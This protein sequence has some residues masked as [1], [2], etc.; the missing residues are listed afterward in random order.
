MLR[1]TALPRPFALRRRSAGRLSLSLMAAVAGLHGLVPGALAQTAAG[2]AEAVSRQSTAAMAEQSARQ[3]ADRILTAVR[4]RDANAYF[5]QLA[6][7]PQR[8]SSP[9]MAAQALQRLPKLESW[10]ISDVV[11]GLDSSSVTAQ[12]KTSAGPREV[13]L[14]IDGKGRLEGYHVNVTDAKAEDVVR[15]FIQA[16][17][18]GYFVT[19]SSY[20]SERMREEIPQPVLQRKWLNLQSITGQFQSVKKIT[21]AE[22]NEQM[23]L[24]I[25]ST[26]FNRLTDNLY[27]I[28]DSSNQIIGVDFPDSPNPS[29]V[30]T[31]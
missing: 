25:V 20:L 2:A 17:S 13:L 1:P 4:N 15:A 28:L 27:V 8:V 21:R 12:L 29:P 23:K 16:L 18:R 6:P 7:D 10:S 3:A 26:K 9:A 22:S 5:A 14:V 11:P 31:P 19:A 24:V 30:I